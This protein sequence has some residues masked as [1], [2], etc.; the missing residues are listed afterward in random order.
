MNKIIKIEHS[1]VLVLGNEDCDGE[2]V[3]VSLG[4]KTGN[5]RWLRHNRTF[6]LGSGEVDTGAFFLNERVEKAGQINPEH[7]RSLTAAEDEILQSRINEARGEAEREDCEYREAIRLAE[8][9]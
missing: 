4:F 3:V 6:T 5:G 2:T 1:S 9:I 8:K 7:W